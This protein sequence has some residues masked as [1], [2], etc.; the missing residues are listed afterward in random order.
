MNTRCLN[1]L[2][3]SMKQFDIGSGILIEKTRNAIGTVAVL[4][5]ITVMSGCGSSENDR[6]QTVASGRLTI[7][8]QADSTQDFSGFEV[9]LAAQE[10]GDVDTLAI[11]TTDVNG[12]FQLDISARESGVFPLIVRRAG[13]ELSTDQFVVAEGD[14]SMISGAYPLNGRRLRIISPEN[15]AWMAYINTKA[16][17]N[18]S[19]VDMLEAGDSA[20]LSIPQ[21]SEQTASIL[22]SLRD[23][24]PNTYGSELA[25]VESV[26]LLEGWNDIL[27][28]DHV[29]E[30][31]FENPHLVDAVRAARRSEAR[32]AGQE[33]SISLIEYFIQNVTDAERKSSLVAELVVAHSD[34][35]ERDAALEAALTLRRDYPDSEW[36]DWA[37]RAAYEL[38]NLMPGMPAPPFSVVTR[39]GEIFSLGDAQ[40][41]FF[42]LEFFEP[43]N[44]AFQQELAERDIVFQAMNPLV[45]ETLS[46]S[47]EQDRDINDALFE[48]NV[49]P[50]KFAYSAEQAIDIGAAYN[51]HVLP[52]RFLID[53][54]GYIM[55]KYSGYGLRPL[56]EDLVSV[57]MGIEENR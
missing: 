23:L 32:I 48:E 42:I 11:T 51:I 15:A 28:V 26:Q 17:Y 1:T 13:V 24:Y 39:D 45:F 30:L 8:N 54:D 10:D 41:R 55:A 21:I 46:I 37:A 47:M 20:R 34:S 2:T 6:F 53:R 40:D 36:A 38:E 31:G 16:Q 57:V 56:E 44:R 52:T 35:L 12:D 7:A 33:A 14:T 25:S 3:A 43:R 22:W 5:L 29:Q 19:M 49:H 18:R 4:S 27:A 9:L 50:G